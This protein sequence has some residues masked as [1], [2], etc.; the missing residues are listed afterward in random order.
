MVGRLG[1]DDPPEHRDL[2]G[3]EQG[4]RGLEVRVVLGAG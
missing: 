2:G 4:E 3:T 1:V